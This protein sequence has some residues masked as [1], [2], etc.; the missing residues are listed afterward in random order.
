MIK[1]V[2][3]FTCNRLYIFCQQCKKNSQEQKQT[4]K[5]WI[6]KIRKL[7]V[8]QKFELFQRYC[9]FFSPVDMVTSGLLFTLILVLFILTVKVIALKWCHI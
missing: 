9:F 4:T 5:I 8:K 1:A 6:S 3:Q 7:D 2:R